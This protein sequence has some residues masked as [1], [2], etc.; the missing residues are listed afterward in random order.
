MPNLR[1]SSEPSDL[2]QH[3]IKLTIRNVKQAER[4]G[5]NEHDSATYTFRESGQVTLNQV[6]P[7]KVIDRLTRGRSIPLCKPLLAL[8]GGSLVL[9]ALV[10]IDL[11][12]TGLSCSL[13]H[14]EFN[15]G[16]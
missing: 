6:Y 8:Y 1:V 15:D 9:W 14:N 10:L 4:N 7:S 16:L 13:T 5:L 3:P 11:L 2:D 12:L